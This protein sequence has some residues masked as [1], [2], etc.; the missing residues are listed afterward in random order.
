MESTMT[1]PIHAILIGVGNRGAQSY[2]P[3]GLQHPDDLKYES[4]GGLLVKKTIS[5]L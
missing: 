4:V 5:Y 2:A 1:K 3:Y